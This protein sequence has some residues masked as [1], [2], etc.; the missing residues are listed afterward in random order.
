[1]HAAAQATYHCWQK[2]EGIQR[3]AAGAADSTIVPLEHPI[4]ITTAIGTMVSAMVA[5]VVMASMMAS[6]VVITSMVTTSVMAAQ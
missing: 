5:T 6:S 2:R 3:P 1:V 4:A